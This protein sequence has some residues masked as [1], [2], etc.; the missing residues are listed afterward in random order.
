MYMNSCLAVRLARAK[1]RHKCKFVPRL[2]PMIV[3]SIALTDIAAVE[4]CLTTA[5]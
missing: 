4:G 5:D 2:L 3:K 1:K